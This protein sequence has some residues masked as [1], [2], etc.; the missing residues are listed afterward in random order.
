MESRE[1]CGVERERGVC[2]SEEREECVCV[3]RERERV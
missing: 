3:C 2:V 1:V